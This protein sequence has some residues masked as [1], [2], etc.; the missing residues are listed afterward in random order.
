M[1]DAFRFA[2]FRALLSRGLPAVLV[3]NAAIVALNGKFRKGTIDFVDELFASAE[4]ALSA[5]RPATV[6]VTQ[7]QPAAVS[8]TP[9][10]TAPVTPSSD[11]TTSTAIPAKRW[12]N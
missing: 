6:Q 1:V 8:T 7:P 2:R 10:A 5:G 9:Q 11:H 3:R 4:L 12:Y